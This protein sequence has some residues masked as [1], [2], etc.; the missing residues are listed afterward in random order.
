MWRDGRPWPSSVR[1]RACYTC[2]EGAECIKSG[3]VVTTVK[4]CVFIRNTKN[5]TRLGWPNAD[6]RFSP[7]YFLDETL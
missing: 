5:T 2:I 3:G 6:E 1:S 7:F 4:N